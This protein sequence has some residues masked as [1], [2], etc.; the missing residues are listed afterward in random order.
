[1]AIGQAD[2][3]RPGSAMWWKG[4]G[5]SAEVADGKRQWSMDV[6]RLV[7]ASQPS[8]LLGVRS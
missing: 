8:G 1:M 4:R 3:L 5:L 7:A 6:V 2:G